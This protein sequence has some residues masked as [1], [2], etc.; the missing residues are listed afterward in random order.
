MLEDLV[1][2]ELTG[3]SEY[4]PV[5]VKKNGGLHTGDSALLR[6]WIPLGIIVR[7]EAQQQG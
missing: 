7:I 1:M 3:K 4:I 5:Q 2:D 6:D